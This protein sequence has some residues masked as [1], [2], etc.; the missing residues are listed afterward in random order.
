MDGDHE[1]NMA[2]RLGMLVSTTGCATCQ[3]THGA[4]GKHDHKIVSTHT[5]PTHHLCEVTRSTDAPIVGVA[6]GL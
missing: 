4:K 5:K 2:S 6:V 1:P 3:P